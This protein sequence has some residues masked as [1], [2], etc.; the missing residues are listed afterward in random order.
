MGLTFQLR[1]Q[2]ET[3]LKAEPLSSSTNLFTYEIEIRVFVITFS[4]RRIL[5]RPLGQME[6]FADVR[7]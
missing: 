2:T 3:F 1:D 5:E 6:I 7:D 4:L